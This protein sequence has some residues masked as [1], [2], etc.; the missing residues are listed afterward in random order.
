[1]ATQG[2]KKKATKHNPVI[3]VAA[4]PEVAALP[5]AG[6]LSNFPRSAETA[7]KRPQE[8]G[9][10]TTATTENNAISVTNEQRHRMI[11]RAAYRRATQAGLGH[12]DPF[13]DWLI[14]EREVDA[15]IASGS[16]KNAVACP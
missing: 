8:P 6:L 3:L 4:Q 14:A 1:M 15:M 5:V 10:G 11:S 12:T 13:Q 2:R 7:T 9:I 16:H